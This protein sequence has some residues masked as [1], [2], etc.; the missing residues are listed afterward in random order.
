MQ[1]IIKN[2]NR[3]IVYEEV[4]RF[5]K[6]AENESIKLVAMQ[7]VVIQHPTEP[8]SILVVPFNRICIRRSKRAIDPINPLSYNR[9]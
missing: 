6:W 7:A 8:K 9:Y 4:S 2:K 3:T 5:G 1:S